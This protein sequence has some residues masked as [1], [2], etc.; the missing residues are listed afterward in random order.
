MLK[1]AIRTLLGKIYYNRDL[2]RGLEDRLE[3]L[4]KKSK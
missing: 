1:D 2:I 3:I 4:E